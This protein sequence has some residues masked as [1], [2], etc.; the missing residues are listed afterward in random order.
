MRA[1]DEKLAETLLSAGLLHMS[2]SARAGYYNDFFSLHPTP[3]LKLTSDLDAALG[4]ATDQQQ[5]LA[6]AR[7]IDRHKNG[8]FDATPEEAAEW[9]RSPEGRKAAFKLVKGK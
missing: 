2:R 1:S 9:D 4:K 5:K 6:I 7:I 8:E 3:A